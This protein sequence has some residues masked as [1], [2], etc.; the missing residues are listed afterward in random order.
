M[1]SILIKSQDGKFTGLCKY[2]GIGKRKPT[3]LIGEKLTK[4]LYEAKM[5]PDELIEKLGNSY[6]RNIE[7]ILTDE[8][9]PKRELIERIANKLEVGADYFE[10][11]ELENVILTD[12]NNVIAQYSTNERALEVKK[13]LDEKIFEMYSKGLPIS[14]KMPEK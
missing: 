4:L 8:E 6:R 9:I 3:G 10:E 11:T 14:I 13:E 5:A 7:R 2:I 12:N 1:N